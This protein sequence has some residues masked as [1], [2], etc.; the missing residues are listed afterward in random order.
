MVGGAG[1]IGPR[2]LNHFAFTAHS[3]PLGED[4]HGIAHVFDNTTADGTP[5]RRFQ[6]EVSCLRVSGNLATFIVDFRKSVD[7]A[8]FDGALFVVANF[9]PIGQVYPGMI[10]WLVAGIVLGAAAEGG[11]R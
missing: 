5:R 10:V 11:G 8:P 7:R 2:S 9:A 1:E 4:P 6:G 3:G